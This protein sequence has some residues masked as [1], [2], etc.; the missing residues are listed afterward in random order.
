MTQA[1]TEFQISINNGYSHIDV[2][3]IPDEQLS[4][5]FDS[6][7]NMVYCNGDLSEMVDR[8]WNPNVDEVGNMRKYIQ[9]VCNAHVLVCGEELAVG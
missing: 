4:N 9:C 6:V 7:C 3:E 2:S 1:N 5:V 8:Y